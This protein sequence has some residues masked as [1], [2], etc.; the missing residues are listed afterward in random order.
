MNKENVKILRDH[1]ASL[2]EKHFDMGL[3]YHNDEDD[4]CGTVA[5][6]A[7][8]TDVIFWPQLLG[9]DRS[10]NLEQR[11]QDALGLT[12]DEADQLFVP[13]IYDLDW[14]FDDFTTRHAV[15]V[16][17]H[18][19]ETGKVNWR[20]LGR[21]D[22]KAEDKIDRERAEEALKRSAAAFEALAGNNAELS[23]QP[24]APIMQSERLKR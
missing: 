9:I 13:N 10:E 3:W 21:R 1:L 19:L 7:G 5:C 8:W 14:H 11:A 16:L 20:I 2:D 12:E 24:G 17:D 22:A 23:L 6:I 4:G 15:K 18:L